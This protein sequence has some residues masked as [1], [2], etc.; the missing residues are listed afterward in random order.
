MLKLWVDMQALRLCQQM[1]LSVLFLYRMNDSGEES[2]A[3]TIMSTRHASDQTVLIQASFAQYTL[4][5][6]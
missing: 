3:P 6:R 2:F 1:L 4:P 5:H